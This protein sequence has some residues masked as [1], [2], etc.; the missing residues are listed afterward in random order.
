MQTQCDLDENGNCK[1]NSAGS[2]A[3]IESE[4]KMVQAIIGEIKKAGVIVAQTWVI[5][6]LAAEL[7]GRQNDRLLAAGKEPLR[8]IEK[9]MEVIVRP[10]ARAFLT[11]LDQLEKLHTV[12]PNAL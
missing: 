3:T 7:L 4:N 11:A 1:T 5:L 2:P 12:S 9:E 6:G 8:S 10:I